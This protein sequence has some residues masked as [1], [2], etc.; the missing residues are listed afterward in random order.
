MK[1]TQDIE[2]A[3]RMAEAHQ[4]RAAAHDALA[5]ADR[6]MAALW[7][8]YALRNESSPALPIPDT[9]EDRIVALSALTEPGE[10]VSYGTLSVVAG[11]RHTGGNTIDVAQIMKRREDFVAPW[12]VLR[13]HQ[14]IYRGTVAGYWFD[15]S[16]DWRDTRRHGPAWAQV[17]LINEDV[18][19]N[20][21]GRVN[22]R[23]EL[24]LEELR[25]RSGWGV[26]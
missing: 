22:D 21:S 10:I 9:W 15:V 6:E 11:G 2:L 4:K 14:R 7:H 16:P 20:T 17:A 1:Q 5:V 18:P 25:E 12:R 24:T 3:R 19:L 8:E 23:H 26:L 13:R